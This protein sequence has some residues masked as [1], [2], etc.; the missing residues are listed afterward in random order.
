LTKLTSDSPILVVV[1]TGELARGLLRRDPLLD[2]LPVLRVQ[3]VRLD[4]LQLKFGVNFLEKNGDALLL[5]FG[6]NFLEF[7]LE[8][9]F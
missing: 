7:F 4:A 2:G 1:C 5:K 6:V 9:S 8:N 3:L